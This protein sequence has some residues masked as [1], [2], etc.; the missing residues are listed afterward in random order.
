MGTEKLSSEDMGLTG[1]KSLLDGNKKKAKSRST[2]RVELTE[3]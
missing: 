2:H 3:E 1:V